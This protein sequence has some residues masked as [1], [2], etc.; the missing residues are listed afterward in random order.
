M[1]TVGI[2]D[3]GTLP[4]LIVGIFFVVIGLGDICFPDYALKFHKQIWGGIGEGLAELIHKPK[5]V[6][7][8]GFFEVAFGLF[9]AVQ[10]IRLGSY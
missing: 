2:L 5:F 6:R 10:A 1:N 9:L 7:I 8:R 4:F 3:P